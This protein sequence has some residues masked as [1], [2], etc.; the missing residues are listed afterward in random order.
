MEKIV[1]FNSY[2]RRSYLDANVPPMI[3]AK[4]HDHRFKGDLWQQWPFNMYQQ[5]FLLMEDW[6]DKATRDV[7]GVSRHHDDV[8]NFTMRQITDAFSPSIVPFMNPYVIE[9][10]LK[11]GGMNFVEGAKNYW[12]DYTNW[13]NGTPPKGMENF[14]PGKEVAVTPGK[15]VFRNKLIELIQYDAQTEKVY[16]EPVLIVPAWIMKYYILDLSPHNSLVKY[17]VE[18]GHT[19]FLISWKNPGSDDRDLSLEDY[20]NLGVLDAIK[21]MQEM[22]PEQKIHA[23]GYC[24]GGTLLMIAASFLAKSTNSCLGTITNLATQIDFEEAGELMLFIDESQLDEIEDSMWEQGYLDGRQMA[25]AFYLLRSNDLIWSKVIHDYHLGKRQ[26]LNDLMAW[27]ADA[28]RMP[29]KMHSEYLRRLFLN[30]ELSEG[31]Y[32]INRETIA[33]TDIRAPIFSVATVSDH[34]APWESV[35][36]IHLYTDADV[37]FVLTTGGHNAG[38]VSEIGHPGRQ[39][40]I[41]TSKSMDVFIEPSTWVGKVPV[42][43]GSWWPEWEKWLAK[44]SGAKINASERIAVTKRRSIC[45]AP[46]TYVHER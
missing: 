22:V 18:N 16:P 9:A 3:M 31:R 11:E 24:L 36:K 6:W 30:N 33:L 32:T 45:Q 20:L 2:V 46:G 13:I 41:S 28:T 8:V 37:T 38:I 34:V 4:P 12:E 1:I 15:I 39:Y 29:F 40:Q 42:K 19:V 10:T 23:A 35:Y 17:L 5:G 7:P 44:Y 21:V 25:G 26:P 27:N 43:N 14:I